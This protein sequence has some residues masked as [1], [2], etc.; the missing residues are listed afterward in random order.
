M[1]AVL[2]DQQRDPQTRAVRQLAGAEHALRR[3]VQDRPGVHAQHL[4]L[5]V[6][7]RVELQHLTDLLLERHPAEQIG[8]PLVDGSVDVEVERDGR[9]GHEFS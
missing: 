3:G 1:D 6:V 7:A 8:D 5:E 9:G 2:A 4:V